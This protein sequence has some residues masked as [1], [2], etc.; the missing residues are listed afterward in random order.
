MQVL[1]ESVLCEGTG[2]GQKYNILFGLRFGVN[3]F[4]Y[5]H[6]SIKTCSSKI[7]LLELLDRG[8]FTIRLKFYT[9]N[10]GENISSNKSSK[11]SEESLLL[12]IGTQLSIFMSPP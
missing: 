8:F 6:A 12:P 1:N 2:S 10:K 7:S 3:P 11:D 4:S 9:K 5:L